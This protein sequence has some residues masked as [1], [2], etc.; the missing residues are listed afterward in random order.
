MA[1]EQTPTMDTDQPQAEWGEDISPD[2]DGKLF[3][4]IITEGTG[5]ATPGMGNEVSVHYTGT[6]LDGTVFDSSVQR[7]Q[8]FTFN[9]GQGK[10]RNFLFYFNKLRLLFAQVIKGWDVGVATMRKGEKCMLTC[11]PEYAYSEQG[12]G[13]N[14]PPNSTLQFEVELFSWKG[15]DVT[16]DG[17][18]VKYLTK[19][20]E[21]YSKPSEGATVTGMRGYG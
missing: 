6:L 17:G 7:N 13:E 2:K 12:A 10:V 3:K 16:G 19:G 14:I 21:E 20:T 8:L 11:T 15:E 18:V 4:K 5:D 1:D 9:L